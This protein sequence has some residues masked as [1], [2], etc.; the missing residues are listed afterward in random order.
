MKVVIISKAM[1]VVT[2]HSK[3]SLLGRAVDLHLVIPSEWP[4]YVT[5]QIPKAD[6]FSIHVL[7]VHLPGRHHFH[8]YT[9]LHALLERLQPDLL[10][11]DEEPWSLVT[12]QAFWAASRLNI[13]TVAFTWQNIKKRYPPPFRWIEQWVYR[14]AR[15]IIAGNQEAVAVL[16]DKGFTG[17]AP[18]IPQFGLDPRQ[19]PPQRVPEASLDRLDVCYVGRLIPEKGIDDLIAAVARVPA[20]RLTIAGVGPQGDALQAQAAAA[21][22]SER[23]RFIGGLPSTGV[24]D[25]LSSMHVLVLPSRTMPNWKEQFGRVLVE[26]MAAGVAVIGSSSGEIPLVVSDAGLVFP[27]GDVAALADRLEQLFDAS[28]RQTLV[29]RGY[30]R[31]AQF[32]QEAIVA[33]TLEVYKKVVP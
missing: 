18:V 28:L 16:R 17:L 9:G 1:T 5:E 20:A 21:G 8:F 13:P 30:R 15:A 27:E 12:G 10:H 22:I 33:S 26:A 25:F 19:F 24:V 2:T 3:A 7:P 4:G 6:G 31:A 32:T 11:V 14:K 23:V 29:S